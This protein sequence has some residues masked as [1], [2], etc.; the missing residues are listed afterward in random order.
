LAKEFT[1]ALNDALEQIAAEE[2]AKAAAENKTKDTQ[3]LLDH[4]KTYIETHYPQ[5]PIEMI[6]F[7][8]EIF[9]TAFDST[10]GDKQFIK[11]VQ[12]MSEA[13]KIITHS[14]NVIKPKTEDPL[15]AFLKSHG[16]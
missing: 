4:F 11:D 9:E 10:F 2:E 12:T 14:S 6:R 5:F 13:A 8:A 3:L 7:D 16:L 1:D 15:T